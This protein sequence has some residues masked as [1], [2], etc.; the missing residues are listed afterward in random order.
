MSEKRRPTRRLSAE[1]LQWNGTLA[2]W[3]TVTAEPGFPVGATTS[4]VA[5]YTSH[6]IVRVSRNAA[7]TSPAASTATLGFIWKLFGRES[8]FT[9][10]FA[11]HVIPSSEDAV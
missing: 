8:S 9:F 5:A 10:M 11:D 7:K 4:R 1:P 2:P 6:P 3:S